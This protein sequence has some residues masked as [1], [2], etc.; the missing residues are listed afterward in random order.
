MIFYSLFNVP[1]YL[2]LRSF[3]TKQITKNSH[4]YNQSNFINVNCFP[5]NISN[6]PNFTEKNKGQMTYVLKSQQLF[7]ALYKLMGIAITL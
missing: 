6:N 1:P 7:L 5:Q 2:L 3:R 4:D